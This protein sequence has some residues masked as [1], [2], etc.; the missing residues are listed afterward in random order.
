MMRRVFIAHAEGEEDFAEDLAKPLRERGYTVTHKGTV[1]VGDSFFNDVTT[2]L[3]AAVPVVL[4]ATVKAVG[5]ATAKRIVHAA[6]TNNPAVPILVVQMEQQADVQSIALD[7]TVAKYWQ[8]PKY[9]IEQLA[10]ALDRVYSNNLPTGGAPN[11]ATLNPETRLHLVHQKRP[12]ISKFSELTITLALN[13]PLYAPI[14]LAKCLGNKTCREMRIEVTKYS[15][16]FI[17]KHIGPDP[18]VFN[19][20]HTREGHRDEGIIIGVGDPMR[21]TAVPRKVREYSEPLIIGN[22]VKKMCYWIVDSDVGSG[23]GNELADS[24]GDFYWSN[25]F[26]GLLV[27]PSGMTGYTVPI[28]DYCTKFNCVP[29]D[30]ENL[31]RI[32]HPISPNYE[33]TW[34]D[35]LCSYIAHHV[36]RRG[37]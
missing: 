31:K 3:N 6:R 36:T 5:T 28:Y 1:I 10:I 14:L 15:H 32:I 22:L 30:D 23:D 9:A 34:Y 2:V 12:R 13:S 24:D 7:T 27:H 4:C 33:R 16:A 21:I 17:V 19:V 29:K 11:D 8:D 25:R 20:L 26:Q 37:M 18:F 35:G